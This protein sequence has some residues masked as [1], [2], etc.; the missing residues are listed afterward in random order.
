MEL[1][2]ESGSADPIEERRSEVRDEVVRE[3]AGRSMLEKEDIAVV[4]P[5]SRVLL[6]GYVGIF[7]PTGAVGRPRR[8]GSITGRRRRPDP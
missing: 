4:D 8:P 5:A 1:G 7:T 2:P 3:A 6:H